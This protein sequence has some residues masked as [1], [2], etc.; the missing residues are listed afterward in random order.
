MENNIFIVGKDWKNLNDCLDNK[1]S[2]NCNNTFKKYYK[3]YNKQ[4]Y[5]YPRK[6]YKYCISEEINIGGAG[7]LF[8]D[9]INGKKGIWVLEEEKQED[10][11]YNDFGGKYNPEDCHILKTAIREF[12]EEVYNTNEIS[13]KR[14]KQTDSSDYVYI[15][16]WDGKPVYLCIICNY[17]DFHVK[18]DSK[19][20]QEAKITTINHNYQNRDWYKTRDVKFLL[21]DDIQE[22]K[23]KLDN[24]LNSV[25]NKLFNATYEDKYKNEIID[26]FSNM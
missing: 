24:R 12:S 13:F 16:G 8:Y 7:L 23:Y 9:T 18:F 11:I 17:K 14:I 21:L 6:K 5:N 10:F 4:L 19:E 20:I 22:G 3:P 1:L 15:D 25:L 2:L 26:F